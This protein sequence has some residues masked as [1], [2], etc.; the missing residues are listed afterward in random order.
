MADQPGLQK[1]QIL[2]WTAG[3]LLTV[4][5]AEALSPVRS[6]GGER[7]LAGTKVGGFVDP[8]PLEFEG[9]R[10]ANPPP[11]LPREVFGFP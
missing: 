2:L 3:W 7:I 1:G 5:W 6:G 11:L 9:I 8:P 4:R 10:G